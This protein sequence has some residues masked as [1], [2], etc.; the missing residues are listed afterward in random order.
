M[1]R[2]PGTITRR[3]FLNR[4]ARVAAA[5]GALGRAK[6]GGLYPGACGETSKVEIVWN[7]HGPRWRGRPE[8]NQIREEDTD[9]RHWLMTKPYR[10]FG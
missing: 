5:V 1:S 4:S 9:W 6:F 7:Y 3:A 10:P 2:Y 8:V